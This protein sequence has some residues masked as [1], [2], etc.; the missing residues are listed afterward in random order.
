[1]TMDAG[2][3]DSVMCV[4]GCNSLSGRLRQVSGRRSSPSFKPAARSERRH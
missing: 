3:A 1:M 2:M 4:E